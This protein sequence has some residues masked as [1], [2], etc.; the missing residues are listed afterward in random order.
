VL[1]ACIRKGVQDRNRAR[2]KACKE[3]TR[4]MMRVQDNVWCASG[5]RAVE[6]SRRQEAVARQ[7]PEHMQRALLA[8]AVGPQAPIH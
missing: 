8:L 1:A 2:A 7:K 3:Q 6:T 4:V 5:D